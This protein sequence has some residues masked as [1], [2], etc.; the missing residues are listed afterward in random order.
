MILIHFGKKH[1]IKIINARIL[2]R[3][4]HSVELKRKCHELPNLHIMVLKQSAYTSHFS[5]KSGNLSWKLENACIVISN[6]NMKVRLL[7]TILN[8]VSLSILKIHNI[9]F[10]YIETLRKISRKV[11]SINL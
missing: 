6:T 1:C 5:D 7:D 11:L 8:Q 3:K 2:T 4:K 9:T 10:L